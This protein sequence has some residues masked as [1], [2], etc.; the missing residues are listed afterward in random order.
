MPRI[1][2]IVPSDAALHVYCRGNNRNNTFC[3]DNDKLK[4]YTLL[5]E[6]RDENK[7]DILHYCLMDNHLHLIVH[8]HPQS[9]LSKFMKQA[10]LTYFHYYRKIY[11]YFGHFWQDRFKSNI[12]EADSHLL[13]CGKYIELNPVRAGIVSHPADYLYSSYRFYAEGRPDSIIT[14][15]PTYLGLADSA[16]S[17]RKHYIDFVVDGDIINSEV[18]K[19]NLYIGNQPF[20]NRLQEC[21]K[22]KNRREAR[23]RPP[24]A[25]K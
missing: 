2:R 18:F 9:S 15:S 24:R 6:L 20:I 5:S 11:G 17:R 4:Y 12:I 10:N 8:L 23:G 16:I 14:P 13:Q 1:K 21:Y 25:D 22:I 7:I 19:K 3:S